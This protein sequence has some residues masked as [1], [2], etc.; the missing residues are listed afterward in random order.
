M[1][2]IHVESFELLP[3]I[4]NSVLWKVTAADLCATWLKKANG[5]VRLN[6]PFREYFYAQ[7]LVSLGDKQSVLRI[8]SNLGSSFTLF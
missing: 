4:Q 3:G 5:I 2:Y 6:Q 8:P 1:C 7:V